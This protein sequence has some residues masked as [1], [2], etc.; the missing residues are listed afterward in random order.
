M[1]EL[2]QKKGWVPKNWCFWTVVLEKTLESPLDC[3]EI[4]IVIPKGNQPWIFLGKT[5]DEATA[6]TLWSL[7]LKSY[8]W[9]RPWCWERLRAGGEGGD[10]GWGG[11]M[12]PLTQWSWVSAISRRWW[13][14]GKPGVLQSMG[15]QREDMTE[16]LNNN[17]VSSG[18]VERK[19]RRAFQ[20]AAATAKSGGQGRPAGWCRPWRRAQSRGEGP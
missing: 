4:K 6:L 18:M 20:K 2:D 7:D 12:A 13:R 9:E 17:S 16:W 3:K 5:V 14:T 10:R 8:H 19:W 1:C 11:W 15:S